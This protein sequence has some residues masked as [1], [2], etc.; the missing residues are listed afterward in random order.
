MTAEHQQLI[1]RIRASAEAIEQG[2]AAIPSN[3]QTVA[4]KPGE[5]SVKQ[6]LLHT[7]DVAMLAF[8]L[9][10]RRLL[11]ETEPVFVSYEEDAYRALNP[12]DADSVTD[13]VRMIVEEHDLIARMLAALPD[14]GWERSGRHPETGVR[15]IEYFARRTAEHAEEHAAQIGALR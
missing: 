11:F 2:V 6:V 9:R 8:G 14:D 7:R 15:T 13:I 12:G 4:P 10:I 1:H 5:W 3:R